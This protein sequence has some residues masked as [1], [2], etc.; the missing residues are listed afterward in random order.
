M[1]RTLHFVFKICDRQKTMDFY[2]NVLGMKVL[3]HE[4]F[5]EGCKATCN[6]PYNG[7][8]SKTMIGYGAEDANFVCELTYN[9]EVG[10]YAMGNDFQGFHINSSKAIGNLKKSQ[11]KYTS[12][13]DGSFEVCDPNG[14]TFVLNP[15][16]EEEDNKVG[17]CVFGKK[18]K[19]VAN[20]V[21]LSSS[22]LEKS[23]DFWQN[24]AGMKVV[25][26]NA[27]SAVL[28][29][30]D[31]QAKLRL[32]SIDGSVEHAK[33]F[34]RIAIACPRSELPGIEEGVKG[35]GNEI[36]TPLV[37]LDTPGKATVEVVIVADPDKHE[38]CFVGDEAFRELSQV[39][40]K[41]D[42]LLNEAMK[43]DKSAEWFAKKN[44]NK[45]EEN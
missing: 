10:K 33:A 15:S 25:V 16:D 21:T 24:T 30:E 5:T 40:P 41:G 28:C 19:S 39:D 12:N 14:Y 26:K 23:V 1:R 2:R 32:K 44:I 31:N 6:G 38:I 42:E 8:W 34:G 43:N 17:C 22:D 27:D 35:S 37:S 11:Y 20:M 13:D 7:H 29:Y 9:Y 4:E 3:R 45:A 36:L 18:S